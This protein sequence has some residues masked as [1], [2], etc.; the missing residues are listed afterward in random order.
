MKTLSKEFNIESLILPVVI[1]LLISAFSLKTSNFKAYSTDGTGAKVFVD[2]PNI[3]LQDKAVG[4]T[5]TVNVT[6]ANI[7]GLCG[8]EFHLYWDPTLLQCTEMK[9]NLYKTVTPED[10]RENIW[11]IKHAINN[12]GGFVWYG[13]AFQDLDR[14]ISGGYA[15]INIT[16]ETF[17]PNGKLAAAILTFK[18]ISV[19]PSGKYA[20]CTFD[21]DEVKPGDRY[22][23]PIPVTVEDGLYKIY[24]PRIRLKVEPQTHMTTIRNET[25]TVNVTIS[26]VSNESKL[27]GVEFALGYNPEILTLVKVTEG[28]FL[29]EFAVEPS[30][31][32][33]FMK[34]ER[35]DYVTVGIIILS[36]ENGTWH[37]PFPEGSGTIATLTFNVTKGPGV[38][39]ELLLFN[40][41][42]A[43]LVLVDSEPDFVPLEHEAESGFFDFSVEILYHTV[44]WN[45]LTFT[46]VT[47]SN[48]SVSPF[49]PEPIIFDAENKLISFNVS[50]PDGTFGF[51]N[52]T[53]PKSLLW[54]ASPT[55]TWTVL[56]DGEPVTPVV[57]ENGTHTELHFTYSHSTKVVEI[58]G[59]G[60]IPEFT[61]YMIITLLI[62]AA[63]TVAAAVKLNKRKSS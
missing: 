35:A 19:P 26:N 12:T 4:D 48:S 43:G 27:V 61:A 54:L 34:D 28:P 33:F 21:L 40:T 57:W 1:L 24:G 5:F 31:G 6:V 17:P 59:T 52:V 62:T 16:T 25:F 60:V 30:L 3:V 10:E 9:E 63:S 56:V 45:G 14:A 11:K 7:T 2:P 41:K 53:I 44:T 29:K 38:S 58:I 50:G 23:Q 15:P 18:I 39:C 36:D 42:V 51:T 37:P 47:K 13:Y 22:A 49:P 20:T 32:T 46:V 55:D 8:L